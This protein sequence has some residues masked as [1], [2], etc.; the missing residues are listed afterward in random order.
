MYFWSEVY[1]EDVFL[2]IYFCEENNKNILILFKL[3]AVRKIGVLFWQIA[4]VS[5]AKVEKTNS[6]QK[7][8]PVSH[9]RWDEYWKTWIWNNIFLEI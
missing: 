2:F 6:D 9:Q 5:K 1:I 7:P 4:V 3:E 8:W